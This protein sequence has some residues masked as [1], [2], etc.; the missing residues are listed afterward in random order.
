MHMALLARFQTRVLFTSIIYCPQSSLF[1]F[2]L[3]CF[4]FCYCGNQT[5]TRHN[6][7]TILNKLVFISATYC[8]HISSVWS[9]LIWCWLYLRSCIGLFYLLCTHG[10]T[11]LIG[12]LFVCEGLSFTLTSPVTH[13]LLRKSHSACKGGVQFLLQ[14]V[15]VVKTQWKPV[16]LF[17]CFHFRFNCIPLSL[18]FLLLLRCL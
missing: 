17:P 4:Y 7:L 14:F 3:S 5:A 13:T 12:L 2:L 18:L 9:L 11:N 10:I 1:L 16:L 6:E 15:A 8:P